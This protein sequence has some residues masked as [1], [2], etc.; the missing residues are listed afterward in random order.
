MVSVNYRLVPHAEYGFLQIK[1]TPTPQEI[2]QFYADEFYAAYPNFND[3]ALDVQVRDKSWLNER[4][5]EICTSIQEFMGSDFSGKKIL[6]IGCGWGEALLYFRE[7][8]MIC[9]GFDPAPEAVA[10]AQ[11][12]G[13]NVVVAGMEKM[14]VFPQSYEVVTL[15]NVL[16]HLADPVVVLQEIRD[17]VLATGGILVIDVPNEFNAFQLAGRDTHNLHDWWVAPPGHL[18]YF[19]KDTLC[20][21]LEGL[22]YQIKLAES[23]FPIEM[24]LLFGDN[25]VGNPDLGRECHEKRML[26]ESNMRQ[27]DQGLALRRLYKALADQNLGRQIT[28]YATKK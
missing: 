2:S 1:P 28:V 14:A 22:D 6:D 7:Q 9:Y 19:N 10:Y 4:R 27:T 13:L 3:S 26:F 16:E 17:S 15:F 11:S 25:Y 20:G 18:N 5:S 8:G 21:L 12:R 24:F 23:S